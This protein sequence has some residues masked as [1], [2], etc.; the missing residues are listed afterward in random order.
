MTF[1]NSIGSCYNKVY[2]WEITC[3]KEAGTACTHARKTRGCSLIV[4]A[5]SCLA[6][7]QLVPAQNSCLF[8]SPTLCHHQPTRYALWTLTRLVTPCGDIS[9]P[10][11]G[12][13]SKQE[14][15]L[16][17]YSA[18][19]IPPATTS[20]PSPP[21]PCDS[22]LVFRRPGKLLYY[23]TTAACA[24]NHRSSGLAGLRQ[25]APAPQ[26]PT[27]A[28]PTDLCHWNPTHRCLRPAG[29][30]GQSPAELC[31][32][33]PTPG[34][35]HRSPV[36][37]LPPPAYPFATGASL[38]ALCQL[39][40]I[41][42]AEDKLEGPS[43][44]LEY[45]G[46]L[47]DSDA[48]EIEARLPANK[49]RD[50]KTSLTDWSDSEQCSKQELLSLIGTLIVLCSQGSSGWSHLLAQDHRPQHYRNL[51]GRHHH[52]GRWLPPRCPLVDSIHLTLVRPQFHPPP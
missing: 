50:V 35:C 48:L 16:H 7:K 11:S 52:S 21:R 39:L 45:L 9:L 20:T 27:P 44:Q 26:C 1:A 14:A 8:V 3:L 5:S 19:L 51:P 43:T 22:N 15:R 6:F 40:N 36:L 2:L 33:T 25:C 30:S 23:Y 28:C 17:T 46:I 12:L 42:L 47:L 24:N 41:P 37:W 31:R 10:S 18:T 32:G 38:I 34:L 29:P 13:W 4:R 49:L